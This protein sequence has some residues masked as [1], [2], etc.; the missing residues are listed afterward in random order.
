MLAGSAR[1]TRLGDKM[2]RNLRI[3][4]MIF[5]LLTLSALAVAQEQTTTVPDMHHHSQYRLVDLGTFGGPNSFVPNGAEI[6]VTR[7][8]NNK[9]RI[10]G[11]ADTSSPDPFPDFCWDDDC[12]VGHA[13]VGGRSGKKDFGTLA[14][15]ASSDAVWITDNGLILGNSQNGET[16]PLIPG[17]PEIRAVLWRNR[18]IMD[19]G[20][21]A[22]GNES[23]SFSLNN[24]AQVVGLATNGIAD[25]NSMSGL[26]YQTRAF[27]WQNGAMKDLGTL[28]SG[29]DAAA[30][31]INER[32]QVV[33]WSY[34]DA[35]PSDICAAVY[36]FPLSTG[37][38]LWEEGKGMLDLSGLGG[39]CTVA[40]GLNDRGQVVGQSWSTGDATGHAFR[41]DHKNGLVDLGTLG[42]DHSSADAI[43]NKGQAVGASYVSDN[44]QIHAALWKGS[45]SLDL[46]AVDSDTCSFALSINE[47]TQVVG[48][49]G[50][51]NCASTRAFLWEHGG[52]MVDLNSL[53]S[54]DSGIYVTF[55]STINDR[56]EIGGVG[57]LP[58]GDEHAVLLIPCSE[59][60]KTCAT[61]TSAGAV[62]RAGSGLSKQT[63]STTR[64]WKQPSRFLRRPSNGS[65]V[66][67][68]VAVPL[69][70][71]RA[72]VAGQPG[73]QTENALEIREREEIVAAFSS[74]SAET[75]AANSCPA[76]RCTQNH[77]VGTVCGARLCGIPGLSSQSG[78][79]ST[80]PTTE[81]VS[82]VVSR[83]DG[84]NQVRVV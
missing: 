67:G 79:P 39:T 21:L 20:T 52:A 36:G 81:L 72:S 16:D 25:P 57:V 4:T 24:R 18:H 65:R 75:R 7:F 45:T 44:V 71:T 66:P 80:K 1:T 62:P 41:W 70:G 30:G 48:I 55:A 56:G 43:N 26:G 27:F 15:G 58:N 69:S 37:S 9:G 31:L 83:P 12:F 3:A 51:T 23:I 2:N 54:S 32:G 60:D 8:L 47:N 78:R 6:T 73:W 29:T 40:K 35:D 11:T 42:G 68:L 61:E 5:A 19:L 64:G 63:P 59:T 77:T 82:M 14:G 74:N 84:A 76:V 28:G 17:F 34:T 38:F 49:S 33:G 10:V 53:I 50:D 46:G 13:F 22:G